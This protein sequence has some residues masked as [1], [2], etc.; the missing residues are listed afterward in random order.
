V[1]CLIIW[2][3]KLMLYNSNDRKEKKLFKKNISLVID[4]LASSII[5]NVLLLCFART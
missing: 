5:F 2:Y 4:Y 3:I 1:G